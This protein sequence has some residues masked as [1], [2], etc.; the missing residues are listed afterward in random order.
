MATPI[1][2]S[3]LTGQEVSNP[4]APCN[5]ARAI[6][7]RCDFLGTTEFSFD[8]NTQIQRGFIDTIRSAF[9]DNSENP[10]EFTIF[11]P[12]LNQE[13]KIPAN[14]QAF[15]PLFTTN[16]TSLA[17]RATAGVT[18]LTLYNIPMPLAVWSTP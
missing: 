2:S 13:I 6:N 17:F 16:P 11:V 8:L 4:Q 3:A 18:K 14:H 10:N 12:S 15:V 1:Q 7:I 9:V 5:D